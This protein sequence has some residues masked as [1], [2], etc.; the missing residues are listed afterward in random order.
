MCSDLLPESV[1]AFLDDVETTT[2]LPILLIIVICTIQFIL[3]HLFDIIYIIYQTIQ[4]KSN[5]NGCR[6]PETNPI[7]KVKDMLNKLIHGK[8]S[9]SSSKLNAGCKRI[10]RTDTFQDKEWDY[11]DRDVN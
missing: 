2:C 3:I 4:D 6:N 5:N 11:C 1:N 7:Q 10:N 8:S 9:T